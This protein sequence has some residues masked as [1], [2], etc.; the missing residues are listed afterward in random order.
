MIR[1][2]S[3]KTR[4]VL[5]KM[6]RNL[7]VVLFATAVGFIPT[8]MA[9]ANESTGIAG[10]PN[11]PA[12]AEFPFV[13]GLETSVT[14][15][16]FIQNLSSKPMELEISHGAPRGI[17]IEPSEGQQTVYEA[18]QAANFNFDITV[19]E[20]VVPGTY[21]T[22]INVIE[23]EP[24]LPDGG[25]ST[26]I[27]AISGDLVIEV[28]GSSSFA[29]LSAV[30]ELTGEPT[31]GDLSLIYIGSTGAE[32]QINETT[33]SVI[34]SPLIPGDYKFTF[35]VPGLQ[36]QDFEF[37]ISAD[38][39]LDLEFPIPTLEFLETAAIPARDDR[40]SIQLVSVTLE[41]LNNLAQIEEQIIFQ[42]TISRDGELVEEF[43]VGALPS[44]P[45]A[46][47]VFN[48]NYIREEGFEQ[49]DWEFSFQVVGENF[50]LASEQVVVINSPGVFQ[51]YL[52]EVVIAVGALVIIG[53]LLPKS[54]W[55]FILRR[56]PKTSTKPEQK[57]AAKA[58]VSKELDEKPSS[59]PKTKIKEMPISEP[60]PAKKEKPLVRET[61]PKVSTTP[62]QVSTKPERKTAERPKVSK[63]ADQKP[64]SKQKAPEIQKNTPKPR[65]FSKFSSGIQNWNP[66][67]KRQANKDPLERVL[68]IRRE[69]EKMVAQGMRSTSVAYQVGS[70]FAE[71]GE[72]VFNRSTGKPFT[73]EEV[74]AI[75]DYEKLESELKKIETP[76]LRTE[77]MRIL[78]RERLQLATADKD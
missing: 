26:Y 59:K 8:S 22:S 78:I 77:A 6:L 66:V 31:T 30:S 54:W 72:K 9:S 15:G 71:D 49:G 68:S 40:G 25:G 33:G 1:D 28:V 69:L 32:V 63:E 27:P 70:V 58:K 3:E 5:K 74:K 35:S 47:S 18:G 42:T 14:T 73:D 55:A 50:S 48:A 24:E 51:S 37:S 23:A 16:F 64:F 65:T 44:L 17:I 12:G 36:R 76:E 61:A 10:G 2:Q 29:K 7:A 75:K 20:P 62:E 38:E 39:N 46:G 43:V 41:V 57:T 34:E 67:A 56:K 52:Q 11:F 13:A 4:L 60:K 53:L 19:T 21:K 45:Q